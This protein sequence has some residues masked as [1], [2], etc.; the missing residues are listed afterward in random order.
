MQNSLMDK[1][2]NFESLSE[3]LTKRYPD[4][5]I[6]FDKQFGVLRETLEHCLDKIDR[7]GLCLW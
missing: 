1:E 6:L 2:I 3:Y 5:E 4:R 7:F